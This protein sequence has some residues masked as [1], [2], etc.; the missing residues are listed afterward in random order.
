MPSHKYLNPKVA[1]EAWLKRGLLDFFVAFKLFDLINF[2]VFCLQQGI[3]KFCK[4]YLIAAYAYRYETLNANQAMKWIDDFTKSLNHDLMDLLGRVAIGIPDL[5]G[6]LKDERFIDLINLG[7][8]EGRYPLP[9]AKSIWSKHGF[10]ALASDRT[11]KKAFALGAQILSGIQK[12][13]GIGDL[14]KEPPSGEFEREDWERFVRIW[15][16]RAARQ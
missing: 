14:L 11:D 12:R 3:E 6:W 15:K 8:I 10:P 9:L 1:T 4:A 7:Y 13:F 2:R 5:Q 16:M